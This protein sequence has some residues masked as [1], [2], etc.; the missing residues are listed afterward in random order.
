[1]KASD[2]VK[3][4][5]PTHLS[6]VKYP[7]PRLR[8]QCQP[9]EVIDED[10]HKLID[11]M[12]SLMFATNGVGLA[13]PQVGVTVQMFLGSPTFNPDEVMVY[14]NPRIIENSGSQEDEE[15]CL[16]FPEIFSMIRRARVTT[17]EATDLEGNVFR[18]TGE[19][20][21]ARVFQHEMDHLQGKL[22]V[23][24]MGSLSKLAHRKALKE[25]ELEFSEK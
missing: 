18:Q 16:S 12:K 22:L 5:D 25:L 1:M 20:L 24:R 11:A 13:A 17:I 8:A 14:I 9:I 19:D 3:Q 15:G 23:D 21:A 7:D 6:V 2:L 4:V 10:L